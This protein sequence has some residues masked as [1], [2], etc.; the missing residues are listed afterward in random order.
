VVDINTVLIVS[1]LA[2]LVGSVITIG[3]VFLVVIYN[4]TKETPKKEEDDD[5]IFTV[6]YSGY[7]DSGSSN[8]TTLTLGDLIKMSMASQAAKEKE[9]PKADVGGGQYL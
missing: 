1:C 8:R 9:T 2:G 6:P 3:L 7:G 5:G 4:N